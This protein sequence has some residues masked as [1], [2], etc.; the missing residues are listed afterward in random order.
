MY[1]QRVWQCLRWCPSCCLKLYQEYRHDALRAV[2][3]SKSKYRVGW[4][5]SHLQPVSSWCSHVLLNIFTDIG[6]PCPLRYSC[7]HRLKRISQ[8]PTANPPFPNTHTSSPPIVFSSLLLEKEGKKVNESFMR[9]SEDRFCVLGQWHGFFFC[10]WEFLLFVH[11]L[12]FL[13]IRKR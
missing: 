8:S 9:I 4:L 6:P 12:V 11:L 1:R 3:L 7:C 2:T 13:F 5:R 10:F